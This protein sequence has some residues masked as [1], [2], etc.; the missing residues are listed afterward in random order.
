MNIIITEEHKKKIV[1]LSNKG[2]T[3]RQ[4]AIELDMK[5][6]TFLYWKNKLRKN[7]FP[8]FSQ[9]GRPKLE[10]PKTYIA[11]ISIVEK[12]KKADN[13]ELKKLKKKKEKESE[14]RL[15]KSLGLD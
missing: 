5:Y 6:S 11:K 4:I 14:E 1:E 7:G 2:Y 12:T 10:R 8:M 15:R 13:L 3:N 9:I